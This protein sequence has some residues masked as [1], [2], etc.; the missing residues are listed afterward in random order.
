VEEYHT[1]ATI[2]EKSNQ[3]SSSR[4]ANAGIRQFPQTKASNPTGS[5]LPLSHTLL[6][7]TPSLTLLS[8][9]PSLFHFSS[10]SIKYLLSFLFG[11]RAVELAPSQLHGSDPGGI[12]I[13]A[14]EPVSSDSMDEPG[15]VVI[16]ITIITIITTITIIMQSFKA[17]DFI[18]CFFFCCSMATELLLEAEEAEGESG[19]RSSE[20]GRNHGD[21]DGDGDG[22]S[23]TEFSETGERLKREG[24]R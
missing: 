3:A 20:S 11:D 13:G 15:S 9:T 6:S 5:S 22:S 19:G 10:L 24:E 12:S 16:I 2:A 17:D 21:G 4:V 14:G 1:I 23:S 7:I 18:R 8:L